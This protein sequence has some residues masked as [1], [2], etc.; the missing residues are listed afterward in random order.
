MRR[1]DNE[2]RRV[3]V[4][5]ALAEATAHLPE[6]RRRLVVAIVQALYSARTWE[7]LRDRAHLDEGESAK[8]VRW[9]LEILLRSLHEE[10]ARNPGRL[11][12]VPE[13]DDAPPVETTA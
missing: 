11:R 6:E 2:R 4:Q 5:Q 1:R 8:A 9:A 12:S 10:A 7:M 3:A 13:L